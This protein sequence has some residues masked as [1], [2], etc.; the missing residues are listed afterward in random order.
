MLYL[1]ASAQTGP[2]GHAARYV[3]AAPD[4]RKKSIAAAGSQQHK[5]GQ[6]DKRSDRI[7]T[8]RTS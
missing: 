4:R 2:Q 1:L 8:E 6:E 3:N 7:G 5:S